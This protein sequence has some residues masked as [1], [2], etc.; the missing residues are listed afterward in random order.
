MRR[1]RGRR[2]RGEGGEIFWMMNSYTGKLRVL[3]RLSSCWKGDAMLE[4]GGRNHLLGREHQEP[5]Q[6][7]WKYF[8]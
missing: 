5:F 3:R 1:E 6:L 8:Y 4:A 7:W 2:R